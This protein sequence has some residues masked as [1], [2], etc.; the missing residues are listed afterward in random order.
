MDGGSAENAG[1]AVPP[2]AMDG[3]SAENAGAVFPPTANIN[4]A[5]T[6]AIG[7]MAPPVRW[8]DI[9]AQCNED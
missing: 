8:T 6:I 5:A 2:T 7:L 9:N 1:A 4:A 3:G